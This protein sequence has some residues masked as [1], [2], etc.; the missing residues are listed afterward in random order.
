MRTAILALAAAV[1]GAGR[2]A[3]AELV[4]RADAPV[5]IGHY[6]STSR[7]SKPMKFWADTLCAEAGTRA[8]PLSPSPLAASFLR[9]AADKFVLTKV[10]TF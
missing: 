10:N 4:S 1:S 9:C 6:T 8:A 7:A 5:R 2:P 3:F